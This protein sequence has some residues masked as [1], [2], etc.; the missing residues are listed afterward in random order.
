[1]DNA[2]SVGPTDIP[3]GEP[4]K[5]ISGLKDFM[6]PKIKISSESAALSEGMEHACDV[7]IIKL[8]PESEVSY[9]DNSSLLLSQ[10]TFAPGEKIHLKMTLLVLLG[11]S[12]LIF[13]VM[14]LLI[15][16]V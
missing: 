11:F 12:V 7:S 9:Q 8:D 2:T 5:A 3:V 1:M 13:L 6:Q 10:M 4:S 16:S 15:S 14:I